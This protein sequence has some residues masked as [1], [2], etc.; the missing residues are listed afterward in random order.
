MGNDN[1]TWIP[2]YEELASKLLEYKSRRDELVKIVYSLDRK[3]VDYIHNDDKSDVSDIDPFSVFAI[4]N[5]GN[6]DNNRRIILSHF[7]NCFGIKADLPVDF[8]GIPVLNA[9]QSTFYWRNSADIQIPYLWNLYEAALT[10]DEKTF[11]DFFDRLQNTNGIK[12]NITIGLFWIRPNQYMPLDE[13]SRLFLLKN[14]VSIFS[15]KEITSSNYIALL[16]D[17]KAKMDKK[18][19]A[20][21]SYDAFVSVKTEKANY[22]CA[23]HNFSGNEPQLERF[24]NE[25][26]WEGRFDDVK[27]KKQIEYAQKISV[28]DILIL[29]ST[30]TKGTN[31]DLPCLRI[32]ALASVINKK[33]ITESGKTRIICSV[34]YFSTAKKDFEGKTYG[35]YQ[36]TIQECK[37]VKIINYIKE[38]MQTD[39]LWMWNKNEI[40]NDGSDVFS[41][42]ILKMGNSAQGKLNFESIETK[43]DLRDEYQK[44]VGNT[45]V[46]MPNMYWQFMHEVKPNDIVVVFETVKENSKQNHLLYGWGRFTS[47][48]QFVSTDNNPIQRKVKW[49]LPLLPEPIKETTTS[50][51]LFFHLIKGAEAAN[52]KKLLGIDNDQNESIMQ[53]VKIQEYIKLLKT[54]R[55]LIL[56]GAPGTGKTYLA[57]Q[58]AQAMGCSDNEIGFVQFHPSYDYTDFVEGLRPLQDESGAVGFERKDGVFKEF[59]VKAL[60]NFENSQ[61]GE[62]VLSQEYSVEKLYE[63]LLSKIESEEI[64]NIPLKTE[65][66]TLQVEKV[67]NFNNIILKSPNSTTPHTVSLKR[68]LKLSKQYPDKKSLEEISNISEAVKRTIGG[69]HESA[70]WAVLHLMYE[71]NPTIQIERP[72]KIEK[73]NYV[74]IIDEINRGEISKIFGELFFSIDPGYRGIKGKV[75]TQYANMETEPNDF[76]EALGEKGKNLGHFF[77]PE[78]VYIIGTMNDIDR[79]VESMDFAFRRRFAFVEV[80]AGENTGMF[81]GMEWKDEAIE[82]MN[83]LNDEIEKI[84]GLSS[85]YHIGASYFLKLENYNGDFEQLWKYHLEGLLREYLRG[86]QDVDEKMKKFENAYNLI[87]ATANDSDSDNR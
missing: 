69:C 33:E 31:H 55:N 7:K 62:I 12:W 82:R 75:Q 5:R 41:T 53:N 65:G 79:S 63:Q 38:Q 24:I 19:P 26:V 17:I 32:S 10:D 50:N 85:A 21:L 60:D 36:R 47:D 35:Q 20:E 42:N 11:A 4:F 73:K 40:W 58:I 59:C 22:W 70:Y 64:I 56:T 57:K 67:S 52:I 46:A 48:C 27:D 72:I 78:N 76:D 86:T 2:F 29:K 49:H 1:F 74:F 80:K 77:V 66:K 23:G 43:E 28:G 25:N 68:I 30:F 14:S 51:S 44:I 16:D 34:N 45:D 39:R 71:Q 83:S 6:T 81:D 15:D 54:N 18:T 61:K 8:D 37:D 13:K 3:Y 87:N 84:D 9:Q